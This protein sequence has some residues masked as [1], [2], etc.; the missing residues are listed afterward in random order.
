[1]SLGLYACSW[2]PRCTCV[3]LL[4]CSQLQCC[5]AGAPRASPP[6]AAPTPVSMKLKRPR[7]GRVQTRDSWTVAKRPKPPSTRIRWLRAGLRWNRHRAWT[8]PARPRLRVPRWATFHRRV[9]QGRQRL[10]SRPLPS[11]QQGLRRTGILRTR[12]T[13]RFHPMGAPA[14]GRRPCRA[15][16]NE[17][18]VRHVRAATP[19]IRAS[20]RPWPW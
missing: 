1:M 16:F 5:C 8:A 10:L 9:G 7:L 11:L 15:R 12:P 13:R 17:C 14:W 18:C 3:P 20:S 2:R 4:A 19:V 6:R